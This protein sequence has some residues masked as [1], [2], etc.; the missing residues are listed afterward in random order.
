LDNSDQA[1]QNTVGYGGVSDLRVPGADRELAGQHGRPF[2]ITLITDL[3]EC[4]PSTIIERRHCPVVHDQDVD[5]AELPQSFSVAAV[6][7]S[8]FQFPEQ[9]LGSDKQCR[10]PVATGLMSEGPR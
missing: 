1:V 8:H 4:P 9:L 10:E 6:S 5:P 3:Q 7:S 2:L